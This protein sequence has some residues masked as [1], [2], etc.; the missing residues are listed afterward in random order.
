MNRKFE[1]DQAG[2]EQ[3][4]GTA[5]VDRPHRAF[6]L[7]FTDQLHAARIEHRIVIVCDQRA[8]EVGAEEPN[9]AV[10]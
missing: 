7:Q 10:H 8:V 3:L 1:I 4:D 6:V 2:L 9:F 5:G